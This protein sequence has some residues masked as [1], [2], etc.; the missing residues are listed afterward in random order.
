MKYICTVLLVLILAALYLS[1]TVEN[2]T[3]TSVTLITPFKGTLAEEAADFTQE[4]VRVRASAPLVLEDIFIKE[5][6]ILQPGDRIAS[7][8]SVALDRELEKADGAAREFLEKIRENGYILTTDAPGEIAEVS[9]RTDASVNADAILYKYIP[10][11]AVKPEEML[12]VYDVIVPLTALTPLAD[13]KFAVYYAV[14]LTG[15]GEEGQYQ[16]IR[17]EVKLLA[18]DDTHAALD[19]AIWD[20]SLVIAAADKPVAH[21]QKVKSQ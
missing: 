7:V 14:P 9:V 2:L 12:T 18:Q 16:V 13:E 4:V 20:G 3:L 11:D 1:R 15:K 5:G 19:T 8:Y 17:R 6:S 10:E 21:M